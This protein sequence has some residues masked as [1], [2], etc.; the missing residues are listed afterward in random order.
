MGSKGR[1][2]VESYFSQEEI[3]LQTEKVWNHSL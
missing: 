2:M 3:A 1:R